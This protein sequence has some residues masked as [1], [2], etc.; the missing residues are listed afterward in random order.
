LLNIFCAGLN[1]EW[2]IH[3]TATA[4][5][6]MKFVDVP[7]AKEIITSMR[8]VIGAVKDQEV[9]PQSQEEC[10]SWVPRMLS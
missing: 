6:S 5:K 2:T 7:T 3:L 4:G 9:K 10:W 1:H 8:L